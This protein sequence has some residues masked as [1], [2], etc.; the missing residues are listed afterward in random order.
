MQ[1]LKFGR[2]RRGSSVKSGGNRKKTS[3]HSSLR[4]ENEKGGLHRTAGYRKP[5]GVNAA[6]V[7]LWAGEIILVCAA[8]FFLVLSFGHRVSNTGDSMKPVI[9]NGE[10]VLVNRLGYRFFSP[11]RGDIVVYS[12]NGDGQYSIKRI[13]G[14]PGETVQIA[15]G[16]LYIDGEKMEEDVFA[17]DIEYAGI[18]A[19][20]VELGEGEYFVIGDN[21]AASDDSRSPDAGPVRES[22]IYGKVWFVA[23]FGEHFGFI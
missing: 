21:S 6:G 15:E 4:F 22:D 2:K 10:V 1:E 5:G 7:L 12:Q 3:R 16:S 13:A 18:A 19:A 17:E 14:L 11:S 9:D 8:A 23:S 20:P